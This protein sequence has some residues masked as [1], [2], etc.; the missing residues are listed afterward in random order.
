MEEGERK[1]AEYADHLKE[2]IL[3][4]EEKLLAATS[5]LNQKE[6]IIQ[7]MSETLEKNE[8]EISILKESVR[9]LKKR[10]DQEQTAVVTRGNNPNVAVHQNKPKKAK[11]NKTLNLESIKSTDTYPKFFILAMPPGRKRQVCPFRFEKSLTD[12]LNGQP[13]RIQSSGRDG[14]LIEVCSEEQSNKIKQISHI[15]GEQCTIKEHTFFN[16]SKAIIYLQNNDINNFS[17]FRDGLKQEYQITD[18]NEATWIKPRHP[19]TKVFSLTFQND[20]IP[21]YIKVIGEYSLTK[22]YP[23]KN[24]PLQCARCQEYGHVAARC[25][26]RASVCGKCSEQHDTRD[27]TADTHRCS[28]CNGDHRAGHSSCPVRMK[29]DQILNIQKTMKVSRSEAYHVMNGQ[30]IN[31]HNDMLNTSA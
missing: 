14:F 21:E 7:K 30:N 1:A 26:A 6:E 18:V 9:Q 15:E 2:A 19:D 17:S 13:K 11:F 4:R 25:S 20:N 31:Q 27:C 12:Q 8:E 3:L 28:N 24:K 22:V 23:Q 16:Q 10:N 5:V 29:E